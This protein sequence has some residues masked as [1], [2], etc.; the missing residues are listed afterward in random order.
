MAWRNGGGETRELAVWPPGAALDAFEWRVSVATIARSGPFSRFAGSTRT[1]VLIDGRGLRLADGRTHI[2]L[3]ERFAQAT[4]AGAPAWECEL[5][6]GP[7]QVLNVMVRQGLEAQVRVIR[8]DAS[9]TRAAAHRIAY[10]ACGPCGVA[11]GDERLELAAGDACQ[12]HGSALDLHLQAARDACVI[13]TSIDGA[14][15]S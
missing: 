8:D 9:V 2:A 14:D 4:F 13:V 7:V 3:A 12:V 5:M 1:A 10:A 11:L 15:P 6:E